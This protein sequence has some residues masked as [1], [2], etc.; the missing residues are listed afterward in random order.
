MIKIV[1]AQGHNEMCGGYGYNGQAY[2]DGNTVRE[3]LEEIKEYAK[4]KGQSIGDG[5][6]DLDESKTCCC[7]GIRINGVPYVGGWAGWK[8]EYKHQFDNDK[9]LKVLVSG[10]WYAFWDFDIISDKTEYAS[11]LP[12]GDYGVSKGVKKRK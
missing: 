2:F 8:N 3:V 9:V 11:R 4:G 6:G 5:F 7:W 10:G 12:L 1:K